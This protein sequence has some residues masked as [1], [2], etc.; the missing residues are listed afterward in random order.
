MSELKGHY[1]GYNDIT[2]IASPLPGQQW[3]NILEWHNSKGTS[4]ISFRWLT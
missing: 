3:K 2:A 4:D 1:Q